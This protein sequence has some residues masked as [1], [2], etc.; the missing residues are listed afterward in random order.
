MDEWE[1][2]PRME[3]RLSPQEVV[4]EKKFAG[5]SV[6]SEALRNKSYDR[7]LRL[8]ALFV[9]DGTP[10][11]FTWSPNFSFGGVSDRGLCQL[12]VGCCELSEDKTDQR[13]MLTCDEQLLW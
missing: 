3:C 5:S 11:T 2:Q 4:L 1:S 12:G 7:F 8:L 9:S 13:E 6:L 10:T